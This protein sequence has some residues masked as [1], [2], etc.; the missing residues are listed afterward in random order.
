M[1]S[2]YRGPTLLPLLQIRDDGGC[3]SAETFSSLP[4]GIHFKIV[5]DCNALRATFAKR[6]LLLR[7]NRWWLEVQEYTFEAEYRARVR[8]VHADALSRNLVQF[9]L[10]VLQIDITESNWI[11][12]AQLQDE[13][14]SRIRAILLNKEKTNE[15]KHYF[16]EYVIKDDKVYR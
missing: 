5:T 15:T 11:L 14:L 16:S 2:E 9:P 3:I 7:I 13:Q 1:Q 8:M 12:A 6:D 10:K 4:V